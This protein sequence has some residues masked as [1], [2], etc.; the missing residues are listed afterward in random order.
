[1]TLARIF[2]QCVASPKA[3]LQGKLKLRSALRLLHIK[4]TWDLSLQWLAPAKFDFLWWKNAFDKWNGCHLRIL[5][6]PI[7][8]QLMTNDPQ[9][10][11]GA[12][13]NDMEAQEFWDSV[14]GIKLSN[15]WEMWPVF[16]VL[17]AFRDHVSG[18]TVQVVSDNIS[19]LAY[20]NHMGGTSQELNQIATAIWIEAINNHVSITCCHIAE[21]KQHQIA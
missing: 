4:L 10:G 14:I 19:T 9:V 21:K 16:M 1:M 6:K 8:T 17:V 12:I 5:P 13:L 7:D 18:E 20:L 11:L 2:G 15:H 3:E